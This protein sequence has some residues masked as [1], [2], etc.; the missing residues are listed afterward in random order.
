MQQIKK[1]SHISDKL[2]EIY[3]IQKMSSLKIDIRNVLFANG[4][5]SFRKTENVTFDFLKYLI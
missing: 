3:F 2:D 4:L 5:F 1:I